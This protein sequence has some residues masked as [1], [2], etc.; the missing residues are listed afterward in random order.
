LVPPKALKAAAQKTHLVAQPAQEAVLG[1]EA[2]GK[3]GLA[4]IS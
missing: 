4:N 1:G 3:H 2:G